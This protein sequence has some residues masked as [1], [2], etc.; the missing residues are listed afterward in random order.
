MNGFCHLVE[1]LYPDTEDQVTI[2]S[3]FTQFRSGYGI[4]GRP[5]AKAAASTTPAYQWWLNFGASVP[6]LQE[7][8]VRILSQTASS[9]EA[10][11]NWN[12]FGFVQNDQSCSLKSEMLERMVFIHANTKLINK[13]TDVCYEEPCACASWETAQ[14]EQHSEDAEA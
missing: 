7:F 13:V 3:Q 14:H 8:A 10:E 4:F 5:V 1:K 11:R 9:S 12:L 2:A 6:E